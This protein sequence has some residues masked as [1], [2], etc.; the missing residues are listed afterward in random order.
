[1]AHPAQWGDT[2]RWRL[3]AFMGGGLPAGSRCAENIGQE[4]PAP[5][6]VTVLG[7]FCP[8]L[9]S[10]SFWPHRAFLACRLS[11]LQRACALVVVVGLP[12]LVVFLAVECWALECLEEEAPVFTA[13]AFS[14]WHVGSSGDQRSEPVSPALQG[15]CLTSGPQVA[16]CT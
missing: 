1:M 12:T 3:W 10:I 16:T 11:L 2:G 15:R 9:V 5:L 8:T 14:L 4:L 13:S 7:G 6:R